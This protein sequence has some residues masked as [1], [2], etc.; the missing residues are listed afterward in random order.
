[1]P[2]PQRPLGRLPVNFFRHHFNPPLVLL[3]VI[4]L[5]AFAIA[6]VLAARLLWGGGWHEQQVLGWPLVSYA[7]LNSIAIGAT[8]LY[9]RRQR[10]RFIGVLARV[11]VAIAAGSAA[12]G[13]FSYLLP[14]A[15]VPRSVLLTAGIFSGVLVGFARF[16]FEH[17]V[18]EERFKNLVLVLGAGNR[19]MSL[20]RLRRR[21]D[22][23]GYRVHGYIPMTGDAVAVPTEELLATPDNLLVYCREHDIDEV[24]VGM[25][26]RRTAF[27]VGDLL[28]CRLA[29]IGVIELI[30]FLE[31]E[32]GRVRLDVVNPSWMIFS[33]GFAHH[34]VQL[35]VKRAL[36]IGA[37]VVL[38]AFAWPILL[39][40]MLA[41]KLEDGL[42][43]PVFYRQTRVGLDGKPF[44]VLKLRSM[45]TD[46]EKAGAQ[47]AVKGD[48]RI[49]R[50]GNFCRITRIDELPQIIN[51]LRGDMAFVG[52]RPERPPFVD[53]LS[54]MI[55]YYRE[56]HCMKPG[57]TGWAQLCYP[58]G[59]SDHDSAQKL[60]YDLYY[61]KNH[62]LLFDLMILMQT[63]EVVLWGRGR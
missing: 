38:L 42:R 17:V 4:E 57:I 54:E 11:G 61:V 30:D 40:A 27:P 58:Y 15:A 26:D 23:R 34:P 36:D 9:H 25:D 44:D 7:L 3:A 56:R 6:P 28:D 47:W 32:T 48:P 39:L 46:A 37:S 49:T 22:Q 13:L 2:S 55:P 52:P 14:D 63:V 33:G 16:V 53:R 5:A 62:S 35:A 31:R 1:M 19:A 12:V 45:R 43:A 24:V 20:A 50:V 51:V 59:A 60:E 29:G 41:I 21:S 18:D 10:N 8:G